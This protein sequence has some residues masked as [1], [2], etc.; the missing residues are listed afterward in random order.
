MITDY[1][2]DGAGRLVDITNKFNIT[3]ISNYHYDYDDGNRLNGKNGTDGSSTVG[4]GNDNQLSSVDN[5]TRPDESYSFNALGIRTGWV[6][7]ILL[8][9]RRVLSDGVYQY[10]YDDEGNLTR[11]AGDLDVVR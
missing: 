5:A 10:Q 11:E 7:Q 2:Y 3:P 8:D 1:G 4:Y 9:K 6:R